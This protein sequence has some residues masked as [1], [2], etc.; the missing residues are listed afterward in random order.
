MRQAS[1]QFK[2]ALSGQ[3]LAQRGGALQAD[4]S[5]WMDLGHVRSSDIN[6]ITSGE[7]VARSEL[8]EGEEDALM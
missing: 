2:S 8:A 7:G 3:R 1:A 5:P 4:P 6:L